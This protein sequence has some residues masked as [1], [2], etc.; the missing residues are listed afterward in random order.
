MGPIPSEARVSWFIQAQKNGY[1]FE[2]SYA[3]PKEDKRKEESWLR[4]V[5]LN[6]HRAAFPS[7]F[8]AP[9]FECLQAKEKQ[10][11]PFNWDIKYLAA[12]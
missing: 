10:G 2:Q 5:A 3:N 7:G 1:K 4:S 9:G 12:V 11:C 6:L 8:H